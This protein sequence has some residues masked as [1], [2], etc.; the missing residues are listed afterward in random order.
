M[1][2]CIFPTKKAFFVFGNLARLSFIIYL[3]YKLYFLLYQWK[4]EIYIFS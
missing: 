4:K 3:I 2:V 1:H